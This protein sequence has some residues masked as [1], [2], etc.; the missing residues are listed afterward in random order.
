MKCANCS[1]C[2]LLNDGKCIECGQKIEP[3][4]IDKYKKLKK[5]MTKVIENPENQ[6]LND[7]VFNESIE[8]FHPFDVKFIE[9]LNGYTH[10]Q[11]EEKNYAKCLDITEIKLLHLCRHLQ[12]YNMNIGE[13]AIEA[14]K[15]CTHLGKLTIF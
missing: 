8:V 4:S 7:D 12:A 11:I 14:A 5:Q 10:Q 2:V 13:Q 1:G 15:Y 3:S 6:K 9:F